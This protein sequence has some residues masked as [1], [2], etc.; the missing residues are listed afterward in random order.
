MFIEQKHQWDKET[1][2]SCKQV[3]FLQ[4]ISTYFCHVPV[5]PFLQR[6]ILSGRVS[7]RI[8]QQAARKPGFIS[9]LYQ[10]S[11]INTCM[12]HCFQYFFCLLKYEQHFSKSLKLSGSK[13]DFYYAFIYNGNMLSLGLLH[14]P[15]L[16][17]VLVRQEMHTEVAKP[18]SNGSQ[19]FLT[20]TCSAWNLDLLFPEPVFHLHAS[21]WCRRPL[22]SLSQNSAVFYQCSSDRRHTSALHCLNFLYAHVPT[23]S[24]VMVLYVQL[25]WH[26]LYL[27]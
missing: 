2:Y 17:I 9:F 16:W 4:T 12:C 11:T 19:S 26:W 13:P 8:K 24:A 21:A 18:S 1:W 25:C 20:Q 27:K 7:K 5:L 14:T 15:A 23:R 22:V 3:F 10:W 6:L